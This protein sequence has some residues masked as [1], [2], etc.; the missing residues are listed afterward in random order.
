MIPFREEHGPEVCAWRYE[1]PY[2]L[3]DWPLWN[4]ML[5]RSEEFADPQLRESQFVSVVN[6][7]GELVGFGQLFPLTGESG[8]TIVRLGLGMKPELCGQGRGFGAA[9]VR[10]LVAEAKRRSPGCTVDLEVMT[11]NERAIRTYARAGFAVTDTYVR[12]TPTGPGEFHC[13]VYNDA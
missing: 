10:L 6:Y 1:P 8:G 11:W 12:S 9:F 7:G 13:M 2:D 4:D 5:A 3:Y